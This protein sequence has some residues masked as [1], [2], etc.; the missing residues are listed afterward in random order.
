MSEERTWQEKLEMMQQRLEEDRAFLQ[1]YMLDPNP[2][3]RP[4]EEERIKDILA[5]AD[6]MENQIAELMEKKQAEQLAE[7]IDEDFN[8]EY[9]THILGQPDDDDTI[10]GDWTLGEEEPVVLPLEEPIK[11]KKKSKKKSKN[12]KD[13]KAKKH[14]K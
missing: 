13:K 7:P 3:N 2:D 14:K 4:A 5:L 11:T 9:K 8:L 6:E 1:S 12:K 10:E